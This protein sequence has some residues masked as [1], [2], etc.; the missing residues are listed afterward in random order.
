MRVW[1]DI[2]NSPHVLF[3]DPIIRDLEA[4][5]HEVHVTARDYAQTLALLEQHGIEH[6]SIGRHRGANTAAKAW[7]L[8]SRTGRLLAWAAPKRF[9]VAFSHNSNDLSVVARL[10]GIPSLMVH[11]Y[12][13]ATLS[14][15]VNARLVSRILVPEA[16]PSEAIVAHGAKAE[17]V[18]HFPGLKEHV[19]LDLDAPWEDLR[20]ALGAGPDSVLVVVRPPA[21]M[22]AYHHFE[23]EL[24]T[25][26]LE[27]LGAAGNAVCVVLPRTAA[28]AAELEG[29][30]PA[31]AMIPPT[32]LDATSLIRS[33]D[34]VVSAGGTM[35]REAA[36]LGTP[37]YTIFAGKPG[38]VDEYLEARG[39]L[40]RADA[41][42][43]IRLERKRAGQGWMVENRQLILG[44][45]Y[46]L[47]RKR[48]KR[49][50]EP[51]G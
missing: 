20:P 46:A 11:D 32:V 8:A 33:A 2:T 17:H 38:A 31:N 5:G 6:T 40:R 3:F 44:E 9:D 15:A 37:A 24:F 34:L 12:E 26:V 22:S 25:A 23:N 29:S 47:A 28:Q 43:D 42:A 27:Y 19:Y 35:N 1:I 10:L 30:L 39:L 21:T 49:R 41:P 45:L 16:I 51:S 4:A 36:V 18:G 48:G 14:Y 7:G 13:H 50:A